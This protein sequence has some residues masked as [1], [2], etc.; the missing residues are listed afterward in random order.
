MQV[1]G[2]VG[3]RHLIG[4]NPDAIVEVELG[5]AVSLD[6]DTPD[7]LRRAGGVLPDAD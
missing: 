7:A 2:D 6:L 3:A 4:D 5:S 1:H